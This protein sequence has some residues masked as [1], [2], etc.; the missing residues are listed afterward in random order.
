[1][2]QD[3]HTYL[4]PIEPGAQRPLWFILLIVTIVSVTA[5]LWPDRLHPDANRQRALAEAGALFAADEVPEA[6]AALDASPLR[7]SAEA[8]FAKGVIRYYTPWPDFG[9]YTVQSWLRE[10]AEAGFPPAEILLGWAL[11]LDR[12]CK[13][14]K[15][16]AAQWFQK[17][18][19]RGE[20]RDARLGLAITRAGYRPRMANLNVDVILR[21]PVADEAR[22]MALAFRSHGLDPQERAV[23]MKRAAKE[24]WSEAQ[25]Q[26]ATRF[27]DRGSEEA[28]LW[29]AMA[30]TQGHAKAADAAKSA[31][32]PAIRAEAERRLLAMAADPATLFGKAAKWCDR[33][34]PTLPDDKRCR[35]HALDDH[36]ICRL[37]LSTTEALGIAVF[38][39]TEAYARC[40][41]RRLENPR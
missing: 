27:L 7:D 33:Q 2:T 25:F 28:K 3:F 35:L 5:Y 8:A 6:L 4:P 22:L 21:D 39:E 1:M 31:V 36:I 41:S 26:Y 34:Q 10:A 23:L 29:L 14:C 20:D 30:A 19:R 15:S 24:G 37:P 18:L 11:L 13:N 32:T 38:E 16:E 9:R 12:G 40:R 17:A